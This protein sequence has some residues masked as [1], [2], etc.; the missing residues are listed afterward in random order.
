MFLSKKNDFW[1][2]RVY[3]MRKYTYRRTALKIDLRN[4]PVRAYERIK[5]QKNTVR[6]DLFDYTTIILYCISDNTWYPS[7]GYRSRKSIVYILYC[8]RRTS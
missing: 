2:K 4:T 1:L 3:P 7:H 6:R 8:F 5:K